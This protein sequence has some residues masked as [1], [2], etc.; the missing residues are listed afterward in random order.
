[1]NLHERAIQLRKEGYSYSYISKELGVGKG[2]LSSWLRHIPYEPNQQTI[3]L[4]GA[5]HAKSGQQKSILKQKS[6]SEAFDIA[7]QDIGIL[8]ERDLFILGIGLYI[9]EGTKVGDQIRFVNSDVRVMK[10]MVAWFKHFCGLTNENFSLRI[11]GYPDTDIEL[12]SLYWSGELQI[13]ITCFKKPYIDVRSQKSLIRNKKLPFG[14][15]HLTIR[16]NGQN[17]LGV[18]LA[19]K[20]SAWMTILLDQA[21]I[22]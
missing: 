13:P 16:S 9:G 14:T 15:L 3:E 1:M 7:K 19:R 18:Y 21:G 8:S 10:T 20:I 4:I 12:S 11:H 5:A 22:V 17:E 6:I 2:T